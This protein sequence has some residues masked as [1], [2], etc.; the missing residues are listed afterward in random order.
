MVKKQNIVVS[1]LCVVNLFANSAY[2]SIAP[3]YPIEAVRKGVPSSTLGLIFAGY[4]LSMCIFSPLFGHM[5]TKMGRKNVLMLGCLCESLSMFCMGLFDLF[6]NP[7]AYAVLSFLCRV[8]EGFGNGC[9][10]SSSSSIICFNYADNMSNLI[11][12]TQ[13]FTGLGMLAGPIFGS[14]LYEWGGFKL[15][16]FVTGAMLFALIIPISIFFESDKVAKGRLKE[17]V[18]NEDELL[19]E[20]GEQR[21]ES[22]KSSTC[23]QAPAN[24]TF[25][26]ILRIFPIWSTCLCM[27]ASLMCLTFKEPLLQ[28]RLAQDKLPVWA[29]GLIFS[30]DTITYSITSF[31]M[32]Y[33]PEEKKNFKRI[34][35]VGTVFFI[36]CM[37][38]SG[39]MPGLPNTVVII[40]VGILLGGIGGAL[41]NNNC[42]PALSQILEENFDNYDVNQVKNNI[43]AINTGAFGLGSILGPILASVLESSIQ[44]RWSFTV[45]GILVVL[46]SLIQ[47]QAVYLAK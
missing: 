16:F 3:F 11:G 31:L 43:S 41:I 17:E 45:I 2:S 4:S 14:F 7:V 21:E 26:R 34:V 46:I 40:C 32:K 12:L 47:L 25:F 36:I 30:M 18:E 44:Y 22:F 28:I 29:V 23:S 10:N 8:I 35:H 24:L 19:E 5:L 39:P 9:L 6:E 38:L 42:V 13:T 20:I 1:I 37:L 15:P 33:I 27:M